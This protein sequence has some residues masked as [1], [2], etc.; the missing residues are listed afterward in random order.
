MSKKQYT[1]DACKGVYERR[2]ELVTKILKNPFLPILFIGEAI[3]TGAIAMITTGTLFTPVVIGLT[4]LAIVV[5]AIWVF[6]EEIL[7]EVDK[8]QDDLSEQVKELD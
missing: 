7:D 5:T 6:A 2:K 3:K 4:L 8:L 1:I